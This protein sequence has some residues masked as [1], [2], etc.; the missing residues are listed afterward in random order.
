VTIRVVDADNYSAG[1]FRDLH[2]DSDSMR[3][4]K[5]RSGVN[6]ASLSLSLSLSF[7][8]ALPSCI[9]RSVR[10]DGSPFERNRETNFASRESGGGNVSRSTSANHDS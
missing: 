2:R 7:S 8:L 5:M 10:T 4:G 3:G 1:R 6:N 9:T